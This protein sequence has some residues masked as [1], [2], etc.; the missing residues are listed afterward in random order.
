MPLK[1]TERVT[2]VKVW[3]KDCSLIRSLETPQKTS[4]LDQRHISDRYIVKL[5]L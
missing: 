2:Q 3:L 1:V 5:L 4:G